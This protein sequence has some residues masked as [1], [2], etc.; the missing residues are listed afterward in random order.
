MIEAYK[1]NTL[2]LNETYYVGTSPEYI[3][4]VMNVDWNDFLN[5]LLINNDY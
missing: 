2:K 3:V 1:N 5:C 4:K